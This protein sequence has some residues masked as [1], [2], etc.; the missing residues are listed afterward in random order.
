MVWLLMVGPVYW[1]LTFLIGTVYAVV[2]LSLWR[3]HVSYG[4]RVWIVL[5]CVVGYGLIALTAYTDVAVARGQLFWSHIETGP[6]PFGM[7]TMMVAL[8]SGIVFLPLAAAGSLCTLHR[9]RKR[10]RDKVTR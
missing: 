9:Q 5:T 4:W 6:I 2:P 7:V 8:G 3:K 1:V 10:A